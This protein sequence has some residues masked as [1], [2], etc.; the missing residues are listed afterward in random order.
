MVYIGRK[1]FTCFDF[2]VDCLLRLLSVDC[3]MEQSHFVGVVDVVLH[4]DVA[5]LCALPAHY[6]IVASTFH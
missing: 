4:V 2:K 6:A 3:S 1:D 5:W